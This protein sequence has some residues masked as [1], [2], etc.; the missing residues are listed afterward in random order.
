MT[1][2]AAVPSVPLLYQVVIVHPAVIQFFGPLAFAQKVIPV[3]PPGANA[4]VAVT[5]EFDTFALLFV[6]LESPGFDIATLKFAVVPLVGITGIRNVSEASDAMV[7][8]FVQVTVLLTCTP[9]FHP[10][11]LNEVTGPVIFTGR[12]SIAVCTPLEVRFPA[13][14][15][16]MGS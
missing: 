9:Q 4:R 1:A 13:L 6:V 16:V 3:T 14:V 15:S 8:V 5:T 11:S 12:V 10:L 2:F 7:V